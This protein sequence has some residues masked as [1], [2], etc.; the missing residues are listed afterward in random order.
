MVVHRSLRV[1]AVVIGL[2][3]AMVATS[4]ARIRR[5]EHEESRSGYTQRG[6]HIYAGLGSQGYEIE[7][8]DYDGLNQLDDGGAFSIGAGLGLSQKVSIYLE[9]TGSEH[10]TPSGDVVF[11][12]GMLGIKYTP[13]TGHR[14]LWQ[15]YGKF[16]LGGIFL[17]EDESPYRVHDHYNDDYGYM[18]P[19][20]GVAIGVDHYIG[21]RT[22]LFGEFGVTSGQL[23]TRV[24]NDHEFE[25]YDDIDLTSARV[26]FGL[27]FRL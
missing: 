4:E 25:L 18:G 11:G 8:A 27:R 3:L 19:A 20:V 15:P 16:A 21:S 12:T 5:G 23:D 22:A 17:F 26:Q 10:S 7:D 9:G 13:N 24:I 1:A 14:H 2:C 6:L